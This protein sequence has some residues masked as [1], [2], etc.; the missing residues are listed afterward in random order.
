MEK[1]EKY[2][3]EEK[4]VVIRDQRV[5]LDRDVAELYGVETRLVNLAVRNNPQKFPDGYVFTLSDEESDVLRS[6][7]LIL[8]QKKGKGHHTK[9]NYKAII[10]TFTKVR[11]LKRELVELHKETDKNIQRTKMQHFGDVLTDIVMPD[12]ETSETESS[13]E[14]NFIIGKIKHTVKRVRN[15]GTKKTSAR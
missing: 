8:E 9:Y 5:L 1:I 14:I 2:N 13:V 7:Y 15:C 11:N 10:E 3:V 12:L 6:K 4:I